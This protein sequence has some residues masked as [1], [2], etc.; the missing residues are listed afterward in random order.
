MG[1]KWRSRIFHEPA[2]DGR[3]RSLFPLPN[4]KGCGEIGKAVS[5]SVLRRLYRREHIRQRV[6]MAIDVMNSLYYGKSVPKVF[7]VEDLSTLSLGQRE[8]IRSVVQKV[9]V[10]GAPPLSASRQGALKAL[11][12]TSGGYTEPEAGVGDVVDLD[13]GSLSLP[14]GQVA[15]VSLVDSLDGVLGNMVKD[16]EQWMLQDADVWSSICDDA[17][18]IKPYNDPSLSNRDKYI[19]FLQH[20]HGCGILGTTSCCRGR[21]GAFCVSKKPKVV[22][23]R[24]RQRQRLI[25]DCRQVNLQFR[26]PPHCELGALAAV[27]E[28]VL[29]DNQIL[30]ASGSDIQD[31]FYAARISDELSNFFCLL[32]DLSPQEAQLVFGPS[33]NFGSTSRISP[34]ITVLPMGFSWSFYLIQKLHEQSAL[35]SLEVDRSMLILDGYPA[36]R[37]AGDQIAAMPYCDNVHSLSLSREACQKGKDLM[38]GDL[39]DLGFSLHE[40][41]EATDFFQTLGGIID[42]KAGVVKPTPTRA[43][44]IILAFES[45]L[46]SPVDWVVLRQLLGH[47]MTIC[48]LNR[49]GMSV[50]RALYDF[51]EAAPKPR[52]LN[53]KERQEVLNFVGLVP[54][55]VGEL[56]RPWSTTITCTDASPQG[57]GVCQ[58]SLDKDQVHNLGMWQDRWRFHHLDPSEWQPRMRSQG[59]DPL[60][61]HGTACAVA[62]EETVDDLYSYNNYFPEVSADVTEP[63]HWRTKMMGKWGNS[64]EHITQK[65]GRA[66]VLAIKRLCRSS[67]NRGFRHLILVDSFALCMAMCKGRASNFKLLRVMQQVSALCL[68]GGFTVRTRWI[69]SER[70]VADG[71]SRGQI[72]PGP[73]KTAGGQSAD[74]AKEAELDQSCASAASSLD[75]KAPSG[76]QG[77]KGSTQSVNEANAS[78]GQELGEA[79]YSEKFVQDQSGHTGSR[80]TGSEQQADCFGETIGFESNREPVCGILPEVLEFLPGARFGS[81]SKFPDRRSLGRVHG[82]HVFGGSRSQRGGESF[83][84]RGVPPLRSERPHGQKQKGTSR[85]AKGGSTPK[86]YPNSYDHCLRPG[87]GSVVQ[88]KV[89]HGVESN[90]GFRYLHETR[91]ELRSAEEEHSGAREESW[92]PI[93]VVFDSGSRFRQQEARQSRCL[94]QQHSPGQQKADVDWSHSP[95]AGK[96]VSKQGRPDL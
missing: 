60:R 68:A 71:P 59:L 24:V 26:E 20:L 36:P 19:A 72:I 21:V 12:T 32:S 29:E 73:Y 66:L 38:C 44:N 86:P 75:Q 52:M 47:A 51:V 6:N 2:D 53:G 87:H 88:E 13:L 76:S 25:L 30:Y 23:G 74:E 18:K 62:R 70:N 42:G 83:G 82:Q 85:L 63:Q 54:L 37:L 16:F 9:T 81:S 96:Q 4:L 61:D 67:G 39:Q 17:Y 27:G 1:R 35:R 57:F 55:L 48:T 43:W 10:F 15:G 33:S 95:P 14:T 92:S 22:D 89:Q 11:R 50:F 90:S 64:S 31:C 78:S 84:R 65:E 8:C 77:S 5:S 69:A 34:C 58:R 94:R 3:Q 79:C 7:E 41:V 80:E 49:L 93:Q 56:R 91:R 45:L 28:L 40:D 46:D